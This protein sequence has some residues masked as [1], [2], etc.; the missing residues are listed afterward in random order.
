[1]HVNASHERTEGVPTMGISSHGSL[2]QEIMTTATQPSLD[3]F[4]NSAC[5]TSPEC[6]I[7]SALRRLGISS[8]DDL[9]LL[10]MEAHQEHLMAKPDRVVTVFSDL[11]AFK[12]RRERIL[13]RASLLNTSLGAPE[14]LSH[15]VASASE[16]AS[17]HLSAYVLQSV[18]A[19]P[20]SSQEEW[21]ERALK[22]AYANGGGTTDGACAPP[23]GMVL[24]SA[25]LEEL[26]ETDVLRDAGLS[27]PEGKRLVAKALEFAQL[28]L[29]PLQR[30]LLQVR[31]SKQLRA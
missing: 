9:L 7:R 29:T 31:T 21:P 11:K 24:D 5:G 6:S 20:V 15:P 18:N 14:A 10:V 19:S 8:V 4:V 13:A 3:W 1:M 27:F 2:G 28:N 30:Q 16:S 22:C 12:A 23:S 25:E 26:L 17:S